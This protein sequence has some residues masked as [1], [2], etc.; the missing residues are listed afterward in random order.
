MT[1][2]KQVRVQYTQEFKLEAMLQVGDE[3]QTISVVARV[4]GIPNDQ[5]GQLGTSGCQED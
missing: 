5:P 4:L 2:A 1:A 3:S